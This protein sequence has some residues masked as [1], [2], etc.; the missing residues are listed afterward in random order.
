MSDNN[1]SALICKRTTDLLEPKVPSAI[2][3]CDV[4]DAAVWKA[5]SSPNTDVVICYQC[6][7][8][9]IEAGQARGEKINFREPSKLQMSDIKDYLRGAL[10]S[11]DD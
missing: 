1:E 11:D 5:F 4:C 6:A 9:E 2:S 10:S 7:S 8:A 3:S